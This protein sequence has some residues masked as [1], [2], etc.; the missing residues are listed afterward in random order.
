MEYGSVE[1][2]TTKVLVTGIAGSGKTCSKQ[3][4]FDEDPPLVQKSTPL[5]ERPIKA[6]RVDKRGLRWVKV[7]PRQMFAIAMGQ[8]SS[9]KTVKVRVPSSPLP[10][11]KTTESHPKTPPSSKDAQHATS[12]LE[13]SEE[14]EPHSNVSPTRT[15]EFSA[16]RIAALESVLQSSHIEDELVRL[17]RQSPN[18]H[19]VVRMEWIHFIDSGGQPQFMELLPIFLKRTSVCIFVIKLPEAL[20]EYPLVA[21][22]DEQG[23]LLCKPFRAAH[24]NEEIL[25][26]NII[27]MQSHRSQAGGKC[28]RILIIGTHN[29]KIHECSETMDQKNEKLREFLLPDFAEKVVYYGNDMHNLIFPMNA[30]LPGEA[31][32]KVA[33]E[34]RRVIMECSPEPDKI[35][36]QWYGLEVLLMELAEALGREVLTKQE[37]FSVAQTLHFDEKSFEAALKYLDEL[38]VIFYYRDILPDVVFSDPQVL[39]D[40]VSELVRFN[41]KLRNGPPS[42]EIAARGGEWTKMRDKGLVTVDLLKSF[43][44]H[45]VSDVFTP[46][47]LV[48]LFKALL[49]LADN[50]STYFMPCLLQRLKD[51]ERH[52]VSSS[53]PAAPFLL[54]FPQGPFVGRFCSLVVFLLSQENLFPGAWNLLSIDNEPSCLYRNCVTF[55][56]PG[57]PG[58]I[59]LIDS[60]TTFEMHLN[61]P[62]ALC[63][64]FCPKLCPMLVSAVLVG[65]EQAAS[66]IGC[67]SSKPA[68]AFMCPCRKGPLHPAT[69]TAD[70]SCWICT[71]DPKNCDKLEEN[72]LLWLPKKAESTSTFTIDDCTKCQD[73][74]YF[75]YYFFHFR[76]HHQAHSS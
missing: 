53:S 40:K 59:T 51:V 37:C 13:A 28:P 49:I 72:H 11:P 2:Q 32:R 48:K 18:R 43:D 14:T 30:K 75:E 76:P 22:Y 8:Y 15:K 5:A 25:K 36:L 52:R 54:H 23:H 9:Q 6:A 41:F 47:D 56:V 46:A 35:P 70:Q 73:Y 62:A 64:K 12:Q 26:H 29:D 69:L 21:Y 24:T 42:E 63:S 1:S 3:V 17:I 20:G 27:T 19:R 57:Y 38:N 4:V 58:T 60:F 44:K 61:I 7:G 10:N 31:D 71:K 45:Y 50:E 16:T 68:L 55:T 66:N 33:E 74:T 65:L 67:V 34:I 39:L